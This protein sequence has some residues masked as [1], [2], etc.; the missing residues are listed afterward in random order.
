MDIKGCLMVT[1]LYNI[2][3]SY[4]CFINASDF[5]MCL[6][7]SQFLLKVVFQQIRLNWLHC[8]D[9]SYQSDLTETVYC[10]WSQFLTSSHY[11]H[12]VHR[13]LSHWA[14]LN[15]FFAPK[16]NIIFCAKVGYNKW[17]ATWRQ[18]PYWVGN[19]DVPTITNTWGTYSDGILCYIAPRSQYNYSMI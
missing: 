18:S 15:F 16:F 10:F 14:K 3:H 1:I 2:Y 11:S 9:D 4:F 7:V 19:T 13:F 6:W 5:K 17:G 8:R 12:T